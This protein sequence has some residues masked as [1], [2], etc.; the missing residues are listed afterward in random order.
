MDWE[1]N[2]LSAFVDLQDPRC[3]TLAGLLDRIGREFGVDG[4]LKNL[5]DLAHFVGERISRGNQLVLCL[6]EFEQLLLQPN[7]F[8]IEFFT[9]L[10]SFGQRGMS[11][12]TSSLRPIH[13]YIDDTGPASPFFNTFYL[14]RLGRLTKAEATEFV[15][16][17]RVGVPPFTGDE[18]EAILSFANGHPMALQVACFYVVEA[19]NERRTLPEALN[20]ASEVIKT[21]PLSLDEVSAPQE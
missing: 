21:F 4:S 9:A 17:H 19:R 18:K 13:Q 15:D 10:R 8:T 7:E 16:F 12:V 11:I 20:Q 6:D 2:L 1:E 14:L 3:Y 5:T